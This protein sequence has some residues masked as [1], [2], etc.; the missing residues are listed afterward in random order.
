MSKPVQLPLSHGNDG[1]IE[2]LAHCAHF[3]INLMRTIT[4]I[5][6]NIVENEA[7]ACLA[8]GRWKSLMLVTGSREAKK[9]DDENVISSLHA[10]VLPVETIPNKSEY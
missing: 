10:A 6:E 9:K 4:S 2:F 3:C 5:T 1:A 7:S 8:N